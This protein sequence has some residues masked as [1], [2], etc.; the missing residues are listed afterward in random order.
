MQY[1]TSLQ[2]PTDQSVLPKP[3]H[4]IR[5]TWMGSGFKVKVTAPRWYLAGAVLTSLAY[6]VCMYKAQTEDLASQGW[7]MSVI[8]AVADSWLS[9]LPGLSW[10]FT[11]PL[12]AYSALSSE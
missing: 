2:T 3:E 5:C 11:L 10:P 8:T 7:F 12:L 4:G 9:I 6:T 1:E